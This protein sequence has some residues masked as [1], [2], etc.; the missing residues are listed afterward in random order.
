MADFGL[1]DSFKASNESAK[2]NTVWDK[3][4]DIAKIFNPK[5]SSE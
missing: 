3:A 1:L 4:F 5:G 2:I